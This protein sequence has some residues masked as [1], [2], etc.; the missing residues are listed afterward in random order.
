LMHAEYAAAHA[1]L[2]CDPVLASV[3]LGHAARHALCNWEQ[4]AAGSPALVH[5]EYAA[6]H[7]SLHWD[8]AL[9]A[10]ISL[11]DEKPRKRQ[12][13]KQNSICERTRREQPGR[14]LTFDNRTLF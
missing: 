7:A 5:A 11:P 4:V 6:A 3:T 12:R 2:H 10:V 13:R 8:R 1:S 9:A 14:L